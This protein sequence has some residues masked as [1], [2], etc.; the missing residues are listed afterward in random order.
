VRT[1]QIRKRVE[2]LAVV[3]QPE[4]KR[5]FTLEQLC[6]SYWQSER[7]GFLALVNSDCQYLRG[8]IAQF[9]SKDAL[10]ASLRSANGG[11]TA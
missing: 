5:S 9:E 11:R 4:G 3:I 8:F 1:V 10:G 7:A 2:R 6:H